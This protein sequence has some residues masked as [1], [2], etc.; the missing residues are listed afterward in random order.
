MSITKSIRPVEINFD[1]SAGKVSTDGIK[2]V[3]AKV[4]QLEALNANIPQENVDNKVT[5]LTGNTPY[6]V[7]SYTVSVNFKK[8][9]YY[10]VFIEAAPNVESLRQ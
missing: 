4:E 3:V 6:M 10:F 2:A 9:V 1:Y 5:V 7:Y 8:G